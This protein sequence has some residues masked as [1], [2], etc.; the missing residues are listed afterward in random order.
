MRKD[1]MS[2]ANISLSAVLHN[3]PSADSVAV[4]RPSFSDWSTFSPPEAAS[5]PDLWRQL[6]PP[7]LDSTDSEQKA[8][9]FNYSITTL[10]TTK[11]SVPHSNKHNQTLQLS[12]AELC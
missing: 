6:Y 11:Q 10:T 7:R 3:I 2:D 1:E 5:W 12:G 4:R 8:H 9:T